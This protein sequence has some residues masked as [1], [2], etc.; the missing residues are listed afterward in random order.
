MKKKLLFALGVSMSLSL[1]AAGDYQAGGHGLDGKLFLDPHVSELVDKTATV[2]VNVGSNL[3]STT[4]I[5]STE[6]CKEIGLGAH[7]KNLAQG[8]Q[9]SGR[10]IVAAPA[11]YGVVFTDNSS[12][13]EATRAHIDAVLAKIGS[14][15]DDQAIKNGLAELGEVYRATFMQKDG[16][17][18][19]VTD[20]KQLHLGQQIWRKTPEGI[21]N[22]IYH[23]EEEYLVAFAVAGFQVEEI[24]RP[25]FYG[26]LKYKMHQASLKEGEKGLGHAYVENHPFTIF[27][28]V[29]KV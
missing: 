22:S 24:K 15:A 18:A 1:Y 13:E 10:V 28:L 29:K 27:Y 4:H 11:S 26:E 3:P 7:F 6:L 5:V 8:L 14:T 17:L 21:E 12:T 16:K 2:S 19:L 25:C 9:E 20:E 23:S